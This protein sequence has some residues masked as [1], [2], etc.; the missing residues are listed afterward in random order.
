[1]TH[2]WVIAHKDLGLLS[3]VISDVPGLEVW[4]RH[5]QRWFPIERSYSKPAGSLLV[6]RQLERLSNGRYRAGHHMVRSYPDS[7]SALSQLNMHQS[8]QFH[9]TPQ[10]C[11]YS[12]VFALR[13]HSPVSVDTDN[14]T[15]AITGQFDKPVIGI[16]AQELFTEIKNSHFNINTGMQERNEQ[17]RKLA[18]KSDG[19]ST[20]GMKL[21]TA[22]GPPLPDRHCWN[23]T[24]AFKYRR[25]I[26]S[27]VTLIAVVA[28]IAVALSLPSLLSLWPSPF[29]GGSMSEIKV[30]IPKLEEGF[31][32]GTDNT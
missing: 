32:L 31:L 8:S 3:L 11:R 2:A 28:T 13:A 17:R 16:T 22:S 25:E 15:T 18:E 5:T 7:T 1:M 30:D 12:V 26:I 19:S 24:G 20:Q 27:V 14:L 21:R 6:G 4:N 23:V 29:R 10:Y 9:K